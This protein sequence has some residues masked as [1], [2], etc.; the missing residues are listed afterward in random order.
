ML[1]IETFVITNQEENIRVQIKGSNTWSC[2]SLQTKRNSTQMNQ[3]ENLQKKTMRDDLK[4][5]ATFI[6]TFCGQWFGAK[7]LLMKLK[8]EALFYEKHFNTYN[9]LSLLS[10][11]NKGSIA[12]HLMSAKLS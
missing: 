10:Q 7:L 11:F 8:I 2:I 3:Q 1:T 9:S 6:S 4:I 12:Y 5:V